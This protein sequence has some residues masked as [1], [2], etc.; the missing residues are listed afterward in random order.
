MFVGSGFAGTGLDER[1]A[2]RPRLVEPARQP[3]E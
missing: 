2:L 1:V 3:P